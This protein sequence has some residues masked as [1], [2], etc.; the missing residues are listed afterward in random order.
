MRKTSSIYFYSIR[1]L[2]FQNSIFSC[3]DRHF[4][5]MLQFFQSAFPI[6]HCLIHCRRSGRSILAKHGFY[7]HPISF[8]HVSSTSVPWRVHFCIDFPLNSCC[9]FPIWL[10]CVLVCCQCDS[11]CFQYVVVC[12]QI[13]RLNVVENSIAGD[14]LV[15][16]DRNRLVDFLGRGHASNDMVLARLTDHDE[17][18]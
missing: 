16:Y 5:A 6:D 18:L 15:N 11:I 8:A 14:G 1:R 10:Q 17:Q 12:F 3:G 4:V 9:S 7:W 2:T 13:C